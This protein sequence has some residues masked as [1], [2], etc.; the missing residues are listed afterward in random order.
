MNRIAILIALLSIAAFAQKSGKTPP[1]TKGNDP[2]LI[3]R[4]LHS[5]LE[6]WENLQRKHLSEGNEEYGSF[7]QIGYTA[8]ESA[9]FTIKEKNSPVAKGFTAKTKL[10]IGSCPAGSVFEFELGCEGMCYGNATIPKAC[11]SIT[12]KFINDFANRYTETYDAEG[13]G[14]H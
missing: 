1:A 10:K 7:K 2:N 9:N 4:E 3:M 6:Y 12:P 8:L 13:D 14:F 11:K 5:A